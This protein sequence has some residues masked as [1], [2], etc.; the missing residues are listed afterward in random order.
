MS[1]TASIG[2]N[3]ADYIAINRTESS[4]STAGASAT[5][6]TATTT[7][8]SSSTNNSQ[9]SP[10][11]TSTNER[12]SPAAAALPIA[13]QD[14]ETLLSGVSDNR[15]KTVEESESETLVN[16]KTE[17]AESERGLTTPRGG[18]VTA[19]EAAATKLKSVGVKEGGAA[20]GSS[21]SSSKG[22]RTTSGG[23]EVQ[24]PAKQA[25]AVLSNVS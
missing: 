22:N 5:T 25:L 4:T 10:A 13:S 6:T 7:E 21:S 9:P 23:G 14:S 3:Q 2:L 17:S 18:H 1:T 16:H 15:R 19:G 8:A 20:V 24:L 12:P 11:H